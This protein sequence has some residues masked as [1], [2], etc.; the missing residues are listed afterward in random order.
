MT[1]TRVVLVTGG[2]GGL[3]N[4]FHQ[5]GRCRLQGAVTYS[6]GNKT[7]GEWAADEANGYDILAVPATWRLRFLR[8]GRGRGASKLGRWT[9]WST[10]P[11]SR[12]T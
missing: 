6:P 11:A 8:Q 4:D 3:G 2:M 5:D 9:C 10:T 7:H 12:A 1:Q